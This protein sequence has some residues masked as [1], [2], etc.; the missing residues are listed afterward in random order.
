MKLDDSLARTVG[1]GYVTRGRVRKRPGKFEQTTGLGPAGK[2]TGLG[3]R[4]LGRHRLVFYRLGS[5]IVAV[6]QA[7]QSCT[8]QDRTM[9]H[10]PSTTGMPCDTGDPKHSNENQKGSP[11]AGD[12]GSYV[13]F[14]F[15][16]PFSR[17][18][19]IRQLSLVNEIP[20]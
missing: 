7:T 9:L 19:L 3:G 15:G 1:R 17:L 6:V 5:S 18:L 13:P 16:L 12:D 11:I 14:I 8:R 10:D 2:C 20:G 4:L